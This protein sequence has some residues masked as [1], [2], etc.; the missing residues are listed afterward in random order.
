MKP[1]RLLAELAQAR[2][3]RIQSKPWVPTPEEAAA[4]ANGT[5]IVMPIVG[6]PVIMIDLSGASSPR[7]P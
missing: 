7:K 1:R 3:K 2:R 4:I 5:L 6:G